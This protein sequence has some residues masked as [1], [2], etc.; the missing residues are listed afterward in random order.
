MNTHSTVTSVLGRFL[1]IAACAAGLASTPARAEEIQARKVGVG[2]KIGN[3]I[4]FTGGDIVLRLIPH[5]V[6]DLQAS[7][8]SIDGMTGY[9]LAPTVKL[10]LHEVGHTPYL[11]V[12]VQHARFRTRIG[13]LRDRVRRHAVT[14]G[15][16]HRAWA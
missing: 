8:A 5:V 9:G 15:G 10:Q 3:G 16:S 11:G 14:N 13:R 4:G 7:Y 12:G 6:F 1:L 2:Y